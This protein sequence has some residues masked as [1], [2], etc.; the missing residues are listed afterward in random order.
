MNV[1]RENYVSETRMK[2]DN[3]SIRSQLEKTKQN[4][5]DH[6]K[7]GMSAATKLLIG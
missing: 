1:I 2:S 3:D 7:I 6:P 4:I 5:K